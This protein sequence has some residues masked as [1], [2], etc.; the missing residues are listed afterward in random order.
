M[1][2]ILS[3]DWGSSSFRLRL[4]DVDAGEIIFSETSSRGISQSYQEWRIAE[5][6]AVERISFYQKI[7]S[8]HII[9][10]ERN[11]GT[12][13]DLVPLVVSGMASSSIG[14]IELPYRK[15]PFALDVSSMETSY[16]PSTKE[17]PHDT[18]IVSGVATDNDVM[19][20]EETMLL[21]C[22]SEGFLGADTT[23]IFP[24]TH[25]K[26]I[27]IKSGQTVGLKT[28]MTGEFFELLSMQSILSV[29]ISKSAW[30]NGGKQRDAFLQGVRIGAKTN[31]L[32]AAF[33]VRTNGLF[34]RMEPEQN[35]HYL[36]GLIIG[37]ELREIL[38][39]L[40]SSLTLVSDSLLGQLYREAMDVIGI[41]TSVPSF[42]KV[43]AGDALIKGQLVIYRNFIL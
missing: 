34:L 18:L 19:R 39:E 20:G 23:V 17:F 29:A 8:A 6:N 37:S 38:D 13:L 2:K 11:S 4:V 41:K 25:S 22:A 35:Y 16:M 21:G 9:S 3:C 27:Y 28:Y 31:L 15:I 36:S 10:M 7:I 14:M 5:E 43:D 12:S 33:S 42:H 26:H 32:H 24:G 30:V 1:K 40:S